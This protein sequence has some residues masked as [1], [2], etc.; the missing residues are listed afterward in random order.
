GPARGCPES[1]ARPDHEAVAA[2]VR[3][4]KVAVERPGEVERFVRADLV[5]DLE[6]AGDVLGERLAVVDLVSIQVLVFRALEEP[7]DHAGGSTNALRRARASWRRSRIRPA[8][9]SRAWSRS[10]RSTV[11]GDTRWPS[12]ANSAQIL[13]CPH[14]GHRSASSAAGSLMRSRTGRGHGPRCGAPARSLPPH[15]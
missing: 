1:L 8:G 13:R 6:V 9:C 4:A 5:V 3:W 12:P 11:A 15:R 14:A 2:D 10:A 7:F